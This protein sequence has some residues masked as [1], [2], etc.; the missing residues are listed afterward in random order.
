MFLN[1]PELARTSL[2]GG[3]EGLDA[4]LETLELRFRRRLLDGQGSEA[5]QAR[6]KSRRTD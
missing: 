2:E 1:R 5:Y 4:R 6:P 3:F